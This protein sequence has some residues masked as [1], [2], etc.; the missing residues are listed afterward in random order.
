MLPARDFFPDH[1]IAELY[2][3]LGVQPRCTAPAASVTRE[4]RG[5]CTVLR[6]DAKR[7]MSWPEK[8]R[9]ALKSR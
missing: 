7:A 6:L 3:A 9:A 1:A 8:A 4:I 2:A 5:R